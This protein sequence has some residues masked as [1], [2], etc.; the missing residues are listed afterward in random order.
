[1]ARGSVKPLRQ[2][3]PT[4]R[5]M[6]MRTA[7]PGKKVADPFYTSSPWRSLVSRLIQIRG[8]RCEKCGKEHDGI[9]LIGDH[10]VERKDGGAE[11]DPTNV[12]I[13]CIGC[14]NTKTALAAKARLTQNL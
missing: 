10:I 13:I 1:M 8:R 9:R 14:H 12:Q 4:V 7:L 6:D 3:G 5:P 11:L 2:L